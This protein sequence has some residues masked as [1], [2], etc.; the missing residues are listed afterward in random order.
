MLHFH[1]FHLEGVF[2]EK[3]HS[4]CQWYNCHDGAFGSLNTPAD[5]V[6]SL[7]CSFGSNEYL[8]DMERTTKKATDQVR[9][10]LCITDTSPLLSNACNHEVKIAF[11][12]LIT[13]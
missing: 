5:D 6:W 12:F 11:I 3:Q 2:K 1:V 13:A 4:C 10:G 9:I 7:L 8:S